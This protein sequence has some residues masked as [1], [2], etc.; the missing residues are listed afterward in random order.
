MSKF[1]S[2]AIVIKDQS[3]NTNE[4]SKFLTGRT[5]FGSF[6]PKDEVFVSLQVADSQVVSFCMPEISS[7]S[8]I[9]SVSPPLAS[10]SGD[11]GD[12]KFLSTGFAGVVSSVSDST[13]S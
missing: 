8:L 10:T 4:D 7:L 1:K 5:L 11:A 12:P 9:M 2:S 3:W 13:L 6:L